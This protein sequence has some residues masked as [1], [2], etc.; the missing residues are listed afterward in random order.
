[1]GSARRGGQREAASADLPAAGVEGGVHRLVV[2]RQHQ[3]RRARKTHGYSTE[4]AAQGLDGRDHL[5]DQE[6]AIGAVSRLLG[7]DL[8][9]QAV[10]ARPPALDTVEVQ[11]H[12]P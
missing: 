12:R 11:A 1:M 2:D 8:E 3:P 9:L 10:H 4:R 5:V 7:R 6:R